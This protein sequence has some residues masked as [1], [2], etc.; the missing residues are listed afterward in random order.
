MPTVVNG[1]YEID[2]SPA[3]AELPN[4][5]IEGEQEE[6][7]PICPRD[8]EVMR[9][10]TEHQQNGNSDAA[11][12]ALY[13]LGATA[14]LTPPLGNRRLSTAGDWFVQRCRE[15][16]YAFTGQQLDMQNSLQATRSYRDAYNLYSRHRQQLSVQDLTAAYSLGRT[17]GCLNS[18][19][20]EGRV[21]VEV[22]NAIT[23]DCGHLDWRNGVESLICDLCGA[24]LFNGEVVRSQDHTRGKHCC[25]NGQTLLKPTTRVPPGLQWLE[26]AWLR[27][28]TLRVIDDTWMLR[29]YGRV[30][31]CCLA[32]CCQKVKRR[33]MPAQGRPTLVI[34]ARV[35]HI[36]GPMFPEDGQAPRFAQLYCYDEQTNTTEPEGG[37]AVRRTAS[38]HRAAQL[39]QYFLSLSKPPSRRVQ[40]ALLDLLARLERAMLTYNPF[41]SELKLAIEE[42]RRVH[43][44]TEQQHIRLRI[45]GKRRSTDL[46]GRVPTDDGQN[47]REVA[48][49][50]DTDSIASDDYVL[51]ARNGYLKTMSM[52][53]RVW[54]PFYYTLLFPMGDDGWVPDMYKAPTGTRATDDTLYYHYEHSQENTAAHD[55]AWNSTRRLTAVQF[56]AHRLH[57]RHGEQYRGDHMR[58]MSGRLHQ[59][60]ICTAYAKVEDSR[61]RWLRDNQKVLRRAPWSVFEQAYSEHRQHETRFE[62]G[63]EILLGKSF[64]GGPGDVRQRYEDGMA[65]CAA[66][67]VPYGLFT[68]TAN[69]QWAEIQQSLPYGAKAEDHPEIIARVF[70]QKVDELIKDLT[71][72]QVFGKCLG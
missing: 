53:H 50:H 47:F 3:A 68:M 60:Y 11:V 25:N 18:L 71:K 28:V 36:V 51:F 30:L 37:G 57:W 48:V 9:I 70:K 17:I 20:L 2:D 39:Q 5:N 26:D 69:P 45:K 46:H 14:V 66:L 15:F 23:H 34:N 12:R 38:M 64:M 33:Q 65:V 59:E 55:L 4:N 62:A 72:R 6:E 19:F 56:Y 40:E 67:N 31:N 21:S 42:L 22:V 41:C 54:D 8:L 44:S 52:L 7:P 27:P 13:R 35:C 29:N 10:A 24:L 16:Y 32:L 43:S 58:M 49:L 61:L 63:R 1:E